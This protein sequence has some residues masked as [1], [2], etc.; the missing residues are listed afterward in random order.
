[1][2]TSLLALAFAASLPL[3]AAAQNV[4]ALDQ[5]NGFRDLTFGVDTL[6]IAQRMQEPTKNPNTKIYSRPTDE[7]K[8]G[9]AEL[10]DIYYY[11]YKNQLSDIIIHTKGLVNS[12]A[13]LAAL[14][15]NYGRGEQYN[16]FIENYNWAGRV[17]TMNYDENSITGD[18]VLFISSNPIGKQQRADEA[19]AAKKAKGDL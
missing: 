7:L 1:M 19:A 11:F 8:I 15:A 18:A 12:K 4:K 9:A 5:K 14:Q 2:K 6:A 10:K 3:C 17:V 13:M 16:R